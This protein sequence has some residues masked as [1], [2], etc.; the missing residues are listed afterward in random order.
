MKKIYFLITIVLSIFATAQKFKTIKIL[1][2]DDQKPIA[3]ARIILP[4]HVFFTN[5]DGLVAIPENS[6]DLNVSSSNYETLDSV[7]PTSII[8]LKPL[9]KDI[10][11]VAMQRVDIKKI[12]KEVEKNYDN[13][14]YSKASLFNVTYKSKS[15]DNDLLYITLIANADWWTKNNK[16]HAKF[17]FNNKFDEILQVKFNSIKYFNIVKSDSVFYG[18][19]DRFSQQ[20][21][22]KFFF[23]YEFLNF[24]SMLK[25]NNATVNAFL[26]GEKDGLKTIKISVK[27]PNSAKILGQIIYDEKNKAISNYEITYYQDEYKIENLTNT[28]GQKYDY[29]VGDVQIIYSFYLKDGKYLPSAFSY[30]GDNFVKTVNGKKHYW[31]FSTQLNYNSFK[32]TEEN[33]ILENKVDIAGS[34][35]KNVPTNSTNINS[36]LLSKEEQEFLNQIKDEE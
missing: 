6:V 35:F 13:A 28:E 20:R 16:Y 31:K 36:T 25:R 22:G 2:A 5:D 10:D 24:F 8:S 23:N 33:F 19:T 27:I 17:A 15:Y 7:K 12:L 4:N 30:T 21:I 34:W 1:D 9:F 32:P 26:I 11:E 18:N 29:K 3:N 14:Y